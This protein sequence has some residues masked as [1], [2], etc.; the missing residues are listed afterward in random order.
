MV[1]VNGKPVDAAGMT[2]AA[3][4][5]AQGYVCTQVAVEC[6]EEIIPKAELGSTVIQDGD[7]VEIG[8]FVGGG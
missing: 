7:V 4:V 8:R 2:A 3:L 5:E 6:N 1:T